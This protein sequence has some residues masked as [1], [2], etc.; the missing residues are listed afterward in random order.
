M[1]PIMKSIEDFFTF[2]EF[3]TRYTICIV[4]ILGVVVLLLAG[5]SICVWGRTSPWSYK[6]AQEAYIA[7]LGV[8][9]LG[10]LLWRLLCEFVVVVFKINDSL[11][12]IDERMELK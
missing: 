11:I 2:D 8:I 3:I 10:N 1:K 5:I 7:G 12:S 9:F 4:Y 6:T